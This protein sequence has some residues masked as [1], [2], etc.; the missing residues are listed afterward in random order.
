M[1]HC[2]PII[3]QRNFKYFFHA[4]EDSFTTFV[5]SSGLLKMAIFNVSASEIKALKMPTR[6]YDDEL[7]RKEHAKRSRKCK[8]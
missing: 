5:D 1:R 2:Q 3:C 7:L 4:L 8:T 6:I